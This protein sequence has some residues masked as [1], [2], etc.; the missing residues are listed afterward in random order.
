MIRLVLAAVFTCLVPGTTLAQEKEIP[1]KRTTGL[2][3]DAAAVSRILGLKAESSESVP[4]AADGEMVVYYG[5]WDLKTL[6]T[7]VAGKKR[8]WEDPDWYE[9]QGWKRNPGYYR[10]MLPVS[11]SNR[12]DWNDQLKHLSEFGPAWEPA[13][14][15]VAA[16]A[17]LVHL[18]GTGKDPLKGDWCRCAEAIPKKGLRASLEVRDGRVH[19]LGKC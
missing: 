18:T 2:V 7:S 14:V 12:K 11:G 19:I 10:L 3:Y 15:C 8:M 9:E 4:Q 13:S 17:L 5:G 16:T 1:G 6:R